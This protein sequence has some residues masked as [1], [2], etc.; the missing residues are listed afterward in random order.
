MYA[1]YVNISSYAVFKRKGYLEECHCPLAGDSLHIECFWRHL[2][3]LGQQTI[4]SMLVSFQ[5]L[6]P[7]ED[8]RALELS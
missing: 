2:V 4:G 6:L 1:F 8:H 3:S 5:F 7:K